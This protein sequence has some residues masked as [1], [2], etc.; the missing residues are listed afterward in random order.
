MSGAPYIIS[1]SQAGYLKYEFD[2][3]TYLAWDALNPIQLSDSSRWYFTGA[4]LYYYDGT[5]PLTFA[6]PNSAVLTIQ[7]TNQTSDFLFAFGGAAGLDIN[8]DYGLLFS[9]GTKPTVQTTPYN[10][11]GDYFLTNSDSI[12]GGDGTL[13][14]YLFGFRLL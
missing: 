2:A 11:K 10:T 3:A 5:N 13:V 7:D 12:T 4:G 8:Q 9:P 14:L 6:N 1:T